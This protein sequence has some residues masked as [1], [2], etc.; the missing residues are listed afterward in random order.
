MA[1]SGD[2]DLA[3]DRRAGRSVNLLRP[4]RPTALPAGG[5]RCRVTEEI[6]TVH[7]ENL[8]VCGARK[9]HAELNRRRAG[10]GDRVARC[11]VERLMRDEGLRGIPREKTRK[12]TIGD[13]A[14]TPRPADLVERQF[15]ADA[16]NRLWVADLRT[17]PCRLG[18]RRVRAR[19]VLEDDHRLAGLHLAAHRPR[20]RRPRHG[21]VGPAARRAGRGR[22]D[23]PFGQG[24][25]ST[26]LSRSP[27]A[28]SRRGWT[29][30]SDP[31]GTPMTTLSLSLR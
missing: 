12:T 23:A 3:I 20:P 5:A 15:A 2:R 13:R 4:P 25:S 6:K 27:D 7:T 10:T 16:P 1:T 19:R 14:Q 30:R 11:T 22:P 31:S 21:A 24:L 28:S 17:H 29:R 9:V 8:G 18:L 26:S